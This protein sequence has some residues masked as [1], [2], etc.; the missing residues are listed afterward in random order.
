MSPKPKFAAIITIVG[1]L[2]FLF[3]VVCPLTP[4][5]LAVSSGSGAYGLALVFLLLLLAD[6]W[7]ER[8]LDTLPGYFMLRATLTVGAIGTITWRILLG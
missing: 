1:T 5:P 3:V 2:G 4:T 8:T 6:F 7:R